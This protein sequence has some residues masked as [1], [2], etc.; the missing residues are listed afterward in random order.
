M[1]VVSGAS[2]VVLERGEAVDSSAYLKQRKSRKFMGLQ[3]E[4]AVIAAGQALE[5]AGARAQSL[6]EACGLFASIGYIP[7]NERDIAPVLAA[8]LEQGRFDMQRFASGGYQKAHPLLTFRCLPNM[9]A[10][11]VSVNFDVQGP[12]FVSY[13]GAGELYTALE[14]AALALEN[15]EVSVALLLG[16]A[17]QTNFLVEHHFS[18]IEPPV[19]PEHLRDAA[20]C[21][22]L[23]TAE[24][25]RARGARALAELVSLELGYE[26]FDPRA[27]AMAQEQGFDGNRSSSELEL[28]PAALVIG[29]E[30]ALGSAPRELTH[31]L[32]SRSGVRAASSWRLA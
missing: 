6:G 23:E 14:E 18:R 1:I 16:V 28:G 25:A 11:H 9:P 20:G 13:P 2:S 21:L 4:L 12:Y 8:S 29:L 17:H 22:V 31:R 24:A 10:Y 30:R 3:D 19:G 32:R 5:A 7:F 15:G 27:T 26:P